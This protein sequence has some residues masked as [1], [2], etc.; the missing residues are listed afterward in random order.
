MS[1]LNLLPQRIPQGAADAIGRTVGGLGITPNMISLL[2]LLGNAFAGWLVTREALIA[3]GIVF[4]VFSALDFVDGAVARATNTASDYGAV[5]DAVLD[6]WGE[7]LVLAGIAWYFG[8][9]GEYVQAGVTYAAL[10]GSVAVSYMR[11]RAEVNGLQMREGLFRRQER[12]VLIGL[13]LIFNGLTV[14]IWALAILANLTALQR[15]WL[16]GRGLREMDRH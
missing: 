3:A 15:F 10:F 12:V 13:G 7:A 4:L 5:F 16:I 8:D 9:R 14:M 2:G 11:A 6:R 1:K